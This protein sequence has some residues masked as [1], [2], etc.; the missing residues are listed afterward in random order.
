MNSLEL[1]ISAPMQSYGGNPCFMDYHDTEYYPTKSA[2]VGMIACALGVEKDSDQDEKL[3]EIE[4]MIDIYE[5]RVEEIPKIYVDYQTISPMQVRYLMYDSK[6]GETIIK[7]R[8][9]DKLLAYD[10][11]ES[12]TGAVK[13]TQKEYLVNPKY[14]VHIFGDDDFLEKVMSFLEWPVYPIYLGRKYC[15]PDENFKVEWSKIDISPSWKRL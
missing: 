3:A 12:D 13:I 1:T 8:A 14:T 5:E 6:K 15:V 4:S 10:G 11:N 2:L 9:F 7:E